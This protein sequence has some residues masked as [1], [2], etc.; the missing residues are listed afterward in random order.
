MAGIT[1]DLEDHVLSQSAK[2]SFNFEQGKPISDPD[3]DFEWFRVSEFSKSEAAGK[4]PRMQV[5]CDRKSTAYTT[6]H[7][8]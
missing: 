3:G 6:L 4:K 2:Y 8:F 1:K 5:A 7:S